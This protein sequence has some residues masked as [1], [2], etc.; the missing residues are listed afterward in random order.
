MASNGEFRELRNLTHMMM[1]LA[2]AWVKLNEF[3]EEHKKL[4]TAVTVREARLQKLA[5]EE[6]AIQART[7]GIERDAKAKAEAI[8]ADAEARAAEIKA[9]AEKIIDR[10]KYDAA[11]RNREATEAL[12]NANHL[13]KEAQAL[14]TSAEREAKQIVD[15]AQAEARNIIAKVKDE[16]TAAN[17]AAAKARADL[18]EAEA[19]LDKVNEMIATAEAARRAAIQ[20][21]QA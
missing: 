19:E 18:K 5:D 11:K 14:H 21:L 2:P 12:A 10:A 1:R 16:T 9:D 3:F 8:I 15:A 6:R 13:Q 4:D 17:R 20:R 7:V